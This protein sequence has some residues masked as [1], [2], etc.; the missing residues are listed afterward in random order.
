[1]PGDSKCGSLLDSLL[2]PRRAQR[3]V[4]SLVD[5]AALAD[6]ES[7]GF[8]ASRQGAATFSAISV[9][10]IAYYT[11]F[12]GRLPFIGEVSASTPAEEGLHPQKYPWAHNGL[13]DT[14]DHAR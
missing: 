3:S 9:G 11:Y 7:K 8:W 13:F 5:I 2:R 14:F 4:W 10:S 12:Y 1:V 6:D